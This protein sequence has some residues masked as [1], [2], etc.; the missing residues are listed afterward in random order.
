MFIGLLKHF[1][2]CALTVQH[3]YMSFLVVSR[4]EGGLILLQ[5]KKQAF[6]EEANLPT[7]RPSLVSAF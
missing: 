2:S 1:D 7:G 6:S 3:W 4:I 5:N